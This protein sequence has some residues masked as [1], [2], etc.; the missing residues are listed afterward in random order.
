MYDS[1]KSKPVPV[2]LPGVFAVPI[3][4]EKVSHDYLHEFC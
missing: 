2:S 3:K 4:H 1:T